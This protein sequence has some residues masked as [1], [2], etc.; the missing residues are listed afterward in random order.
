MQDE[1]CNQGIVR[2]ARHQDFIRRLFEFSMEVRRF[3]LL[4]GD[5]GM[6][7]EWKTSVKGL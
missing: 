3:G 7:V 4:L 5:Q 2:L 6:S 1:L